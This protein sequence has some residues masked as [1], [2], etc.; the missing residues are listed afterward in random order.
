M[1]VYRGEGHPPLGEDGCP[2]CGF[3]ASTIANTLLIGGLP[4]RGKQA[5]PRETAMPAR[6]KQPRPRA[7]TEL[8]RARGKQD[9]PCARETRLT[10][11]GNAA[12]AQEAAGRLATG[13]RH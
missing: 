7:G 12:A 13:R 4:G 3:C 5:R 10:A 6:G 9:W 1:D 8:R 2:K 11:C